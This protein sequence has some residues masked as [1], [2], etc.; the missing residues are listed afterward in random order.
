MDTSNLFRLNIKDIGKAILVTFLTSFVG[1]TYQTLS[2]G[3]I[4]SLADLGNTLQFSLSAGGGYLIKN[5]FTGSSN[6]LLKR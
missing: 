4:P 3:E 2:A 5:L 1:S 6:Q